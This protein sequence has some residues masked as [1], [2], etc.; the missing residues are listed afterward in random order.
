MTK[1]KIFRENGRWYCR[2]TN[3]ELLVMGC[4]TL[5][6]LTNAMRADTRSALWGMLAEMKQ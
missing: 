4:Q 2:W 5:S 3:G 6:D 1:P